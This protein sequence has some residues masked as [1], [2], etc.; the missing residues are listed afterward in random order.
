[1]SEYSL[2]SASPATTG[3]HLR[4][5]DLRGRHLDWNELRAAVPRQAASSVA[6]A[7]DSVRSIIEDVRSRGA[8]ALRDLAFT[9]DGVDQQRIRVAPEQIERAVA[10]LDPAVR[11]GLESA[12]ERT[13][14]FARAQ[15]PKD[16]SVEVAPGAVLRHRWTPVRR[17]GL[18]IPGGLAVYP[19]SVVMNVVPAQAAGVESVVLCSPPQKDFD[20]LPHPVILAAAGLLGVDEVWAVGGAQSLAALAYGITD[21]EDVLE[22]V[23]TVTGPGNIFVAMAKRQL[24][25]VVGVDAEAGTTEIAVLADDSA[26]PRFVAADLISQA[27]HDPA[28]GSVL[29]TDSEDLARAVEEQLAVQV[30][31]AKH[32]ER[33][34]TA[35]GGP[36]SGVVLT[37]NLDQSVAVADAY[38][39]EHLEIHTRDAAAVAARVRN[40]G[41]IFVGPYSPVP[42]GDYA[43]GSNHVLPT[44][45]T[46]VFNSGLQAA[47]FMKAVQ[48][49]EYSEKALAQLED[50]IVALAD[51]E[52]LP[53]HGRAVTIRSEAAAPGREG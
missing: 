43:A 26:D 3:S 11:H 27:E 19:S 35:L 6:E 52:D 8:Q 51:T 44:G 18:Y 17:A 24:R 23:N 47:S 16:V 46:A 10:E 9:F 12:I 39:A 5:I 13:R 38:A 53:A 29:I 1:M 31:A 7:E 4:V 20:G 36:Q 2:E 45:G 42:L 28:A 33:I 22:P 49:I 21:G 50:D 15:R 34:A 40:A 25:S 32:R 48:V 37:N 30:P 14:A 41:A